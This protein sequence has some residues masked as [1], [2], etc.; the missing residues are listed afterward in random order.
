[1]TSGLTA[2]TYGHAEGTAIVLAEPISFWG[3][4]ESSTGTIIDANHPD[5]GRNVAGR[6]LVMS[7]GRGSSSSSSVLAETIRNGSGPVGI[8]LKHNDPILI[9]GALVAH[10]IYAKACPIVIY[11]DNDIVDGSE[12]EIL[13]NE[14]TCE[15]RIR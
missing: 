9:V 15:V 12:I 6:I 1:M 8:I 5:H 13:A 2:I 7:C 11:P 4:I 3:G 10:T 14:S